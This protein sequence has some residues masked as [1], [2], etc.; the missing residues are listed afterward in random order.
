M[1]KRVLVAEAAD[2][3]RS[4]AESVLR[5]NGFEVIS[6]PSP[7]RA[8]EV[9]EFSRPDVVVVGSELTTS[10]KTPLYERIQ[11]KYGPSEMPLIALHDAGTGDVSLPE[12][13]IVQRPIDPGDFLRKI[14]AVTQGVAA[15]AGSKGANGSLSE[16]EVDDDF[17]DAALG[18]D[19]ITVTDSEVMDKTKVE[20]KPGEHTDS[21]RVESLMISEDQTDIAHKK[22]PKK[23]PSPGATGGLEL[24]TDQYGMLNPPQ[25][26]EGDAKGDHDYDW[27]INALSEE[28]KGETKP[29]STPP[30]AP[31]AGDEKL[32][33]D[34]PSE[35]I[36]PVS[37]QSSKAAKP[38]GK[39]P[40]DTQSQGKGGP[41]VEKFID[42]FK[43][44]IERIR[45]NEP[46]TVDI[47]ERGKPKA[48]QDAGMAWEEKL[49]KLTP[50]EAALFTRELASE[51]AD[52][53]AAMIVGKIDPA[54]LLQLI[55]HEVITHARK[56]K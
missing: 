2:A 45:S 53:I 13:S 32:T 44:E 25:G 33:F 56:T 8:L 39:Q 27:F 21:G 26:E 31:Q 38:K 23:E 55:K 28:T 46:E 30:S 29:A 10:D 12:G 11:S 42:E 17:L 24:E 40:K 49:E 6:V 34:D 43:R 20:R 48:K 47:Q 3:T 52:R 14:A 18:L 51:L 50:D 22:Q 4:V 36:E 16:N 15:Q 5:Q 1:R 7:E 19:N 37:T 54:K 41:G 9:L 35:T